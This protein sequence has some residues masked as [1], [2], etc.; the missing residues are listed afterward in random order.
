M[1]KEQ[2]LESLNHL[3]ESAF[4]TMFQQG[5]TLTFRVTRE[6]DVAR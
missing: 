6:V 2:A 5:P 1:T 4:I 3:L